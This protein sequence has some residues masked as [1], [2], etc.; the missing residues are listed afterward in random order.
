MD[1]QILSDYIDACELIKETE[2]EIKKL[3]K[4]KKTIIQTNVKGSNPDF[5]YQEQHFR[6]AGTVFNCADDSALR[7][8]EKILAQR[9]E[10]AERIKHQVEQW[11]LTIPVRMQRIIR[12]KYF[13]ELTYEE[14]AAQIGRKATA[15]SVRME[16]ERFL[17]K[18]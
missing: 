1:K 8:E 5:P 3:N 11:M 16:L 18:K 12:M 17:R 7:Y 9:K 10:S 4:K 15:D 6:I 13:E 2:Q 14:V